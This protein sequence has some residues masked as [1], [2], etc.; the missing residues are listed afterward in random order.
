MRKLHCSP[1]EAIISAAEV[2][3]YEER[4]ISER[5]IAALKRQI[6]Q[7]AYDNGEEPTHVAKCLVTHNADEL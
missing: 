1:V 3:R 2:F 7:Q 5:R 4:N 6:Y